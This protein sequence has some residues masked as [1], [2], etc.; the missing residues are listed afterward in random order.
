MGRHNGPRTKMAV[1]VR[2]YVTDADG[3]Q[4]MTLAYT[5]D[6]NHL[7]ARLGGVHI[8]VNKGQVITVQYQHRRCA[9][10]VAWVG[11]HGTPTATQVGLECLDPGKNVWGVELPGR[12]SGAPVSRRGAMATS[13]AD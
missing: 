9:F 6:A 11:E 2:I 5:L 1:P 7:G 8:P 10:R 4:S 13:A 3:N 12:L